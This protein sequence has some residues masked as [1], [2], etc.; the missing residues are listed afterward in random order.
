[1]LRSLA[2]GAAPGALANCGAAFCAINTNWDTHGAWAEPGFRID[3]RYERIDQ[4]QPLAGSRKVT[5]GEFPR[6]HDEV[7][8]SNRNWLLSLDYTVSADWGVSVAL[9]V[10]R[11]DHF[12]IMNDFDNGTQT[13]EA[14]K[15]DEVGDLRVMLRRRLAMFEDREPSLA[16]VG[17]NVGLKLPTGSTNVVNAEG[18]RAERTLQPGT[19]TTDALLGAYYSRLLPVR[20]LSWFVQGLLQ[21]PLN[22]SE[23]YRP[24]RRISLDAGLRYD[25]SERLGVMLQLNALFRGRD[26]GANAERD[27]T[28]GRSLF[29]SPGMSFEL[30]KD[31]RLY[32]FIQAPLYQ[33]ANGVQL[34]TR[35]GAVL[36][37]SARF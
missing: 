25:I 2:L 30:A 20:D 13:P 37:V 3:L 7:R 31:V 11:R 34:G 5:V 26:S 32:G 10:V 36:G 19:G 8:T 23:G 6:D 9:P 24:G 12:H 22:E 15:F 14:W 18:E 4:N 29:L 17:L 27:D 16:T 1:M 28:G 35:P 21:L 33:Y